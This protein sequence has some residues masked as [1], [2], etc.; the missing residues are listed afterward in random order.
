MAS[1]VLRGQHPVVK[2][3]DDLEAVIHLAEVDHM[4]LA[5][6]PQQLGPLGHGPSESMFAYND[7]LAGVP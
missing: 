5:P 7:V 3:A 6:P 2:D 4:S 1:E